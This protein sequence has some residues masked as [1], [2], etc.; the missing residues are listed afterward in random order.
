ML[1]AREQDLMEDIGNLEANTKTLDILRKEEL[2]KV[3][4]VVE[5]LKNK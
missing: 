1:R 4:N 3:N 2:D 5:G